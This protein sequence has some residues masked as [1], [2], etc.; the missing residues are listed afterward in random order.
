M[1][2]RIYVLLLLTGVAAHVFAYTFEGGP[3]Q[4]DYDE[5]PWAE[6][7]TV[8]PDYPKSE[9]LIE[10]TVGP[11]EHNR[12]YVDG[13]TISIG[14]DG[15]VRYV[16]VL[17]TAGGASNVSL[18]AMRCAT[19]ELKLVAVGRADGSW[20]KIQNPNWQPIQNKLVNQHHAVL[21]RD[22]LC[23]SGHTPRDAAEARA[24]L[25]RGKNQDTP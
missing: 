10:F 7:K 16:L 20:S 18:E 1:G 25:K 15:I 14:A 8:I 24:G 3:E 13:S 21:N 12:F 11:T 5:K 2:S 19:R 17:K 6:E 4:Y 9:D 23:P 22:F